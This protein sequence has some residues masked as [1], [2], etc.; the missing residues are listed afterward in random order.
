M[1]HDYDLQIIIVAGPDQPQRAVLGLS[2]AA[3]AAAA[4]T[5]VFIY[6]VMEG[7]RC[8]L[9]QNCA[10][11]LVDGFPTV[12]E[13]VAAV[14]ES[15]GSIAYCPNC[16]AGQCDPGFRGKTSEQSFC[17]LG[18]PSGVSTVAMQLAHIP[19]VVF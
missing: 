13:L 16:L 4:G 17:H 2:M 10:R 11:S 3:A 18:H 1:P 12:A 9:T 5:R 19:S 15:G 14:H 6:L 8:L 7:A